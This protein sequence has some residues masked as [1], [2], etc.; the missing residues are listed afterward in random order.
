LE[1]LPGIGSKLAARII[2][3]RDPPYKSVD[4]L[5]RVKGVSLSL[6]EQLRPPSLGRTDAGSHPSSD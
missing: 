4:D 5:K 1:Y 6:I 3:N 2:E